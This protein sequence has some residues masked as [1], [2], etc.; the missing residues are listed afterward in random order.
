MKGADERFFLEWEYTLLNKLGLQLTSEGT[1]LT[2]TPN[3]PFNRLGMGRRCV[4]MK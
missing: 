3:R 4:K 2:P 1:T